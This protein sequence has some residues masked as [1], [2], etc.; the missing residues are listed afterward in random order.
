M[1]KKPKLYDDV[2][3][4]DWLT[5][6]EASKRDFES[7][8]VGLSQAQLEKL[9][10][11][12]EF[13]TWRLHRAFINHHGLV[14][15]RFVQHETFAR[16]WQALAE[17]DA[18]HE[19]FSFTAANGGVP[20]T[21]LRRLDA[22]YRVPKFTAIQMKR[23]YEKI[24]KSCDDLL[25]LIQQVT[26]G[27]Q[28]DNRF[29]AFNYLEHGQARYLL[30]CFQSPAEVGR[31]KLSNGQD[32]SS[33]PKVFVQ[34]VLQ[35]AEITPIAALE[36]IRKAA[37]GDPSRRKLPTKLGAKNAMRTY[38]IRATYEAINSASSTLFHEGSI[39]P[40]RLLADLVSLIADTDCT[41]DDVRKALKTKP[42]DC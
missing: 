40:N 39:V 13:R 27:E 2:F 4:S 15:R 23:H 8:L 25:H 32:D 29:A 1:V 31:R 12:N 24:S 9:A 38:F 5:E 41:E 26:P 21:L 22:W 14:L 30:R 20:A 42:E 28:G 33:Y 3:L 37:S 36:T 6:Y 35:Q 7:S 16:L 17:Y 34:Y 19:T 10:I 11:T 18:T